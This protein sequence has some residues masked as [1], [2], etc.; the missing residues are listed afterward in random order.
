MFVFNSF[1]LHLRSVKEQ[2]LNYVHSVRSIFLMHNSS[3]SFD[4]NFEGIIKEEIFEGAMSSSS[5]FF[6]DRVTQLVS[7]F[8]IDDDDDV[9]AT[10]AAR[11][12]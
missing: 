6:I 2:R 3:L 9:F 4:D 8:T 11:Q 7:S 12:L 5:R 1:D 10:L